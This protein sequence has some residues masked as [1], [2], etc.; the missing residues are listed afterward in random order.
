MERIKPSRPSGLRSGC[1]LPAPGRTR[2][3]PAAA[4]R[5]PESPD[6]LLPDGTAAVPGPDP[7]FPESRK[8]RLPAICA[9]RAPPSL[10]RWPV[11]HFGMEV[12]MPTSPSGLWGSVPES[13]ISKTPM[14]A[15]QRN[16]PEV[17]VRLEERATNSPFNRSAF[18]ESPTN[19]DDAAHDSARPRPPMC[20]LIAWADLSSDTLFSR[21]AIVPEMNHLSSDIVEMHLPSCPVT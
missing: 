14:Q 18:R 3:A 21:W 12:G 9:A 16:W 5:C 20:G 1:A 10:R 11:L 8:P 19:P 13:H 2:P 17:P 7:P 15:L 4:L 6:I